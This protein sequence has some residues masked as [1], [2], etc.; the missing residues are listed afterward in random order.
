MSVETENAKEAIRLLRKEIPKHIPQ[1]IGLYILSCRNPELGKV[2]RAS[3]FFMRHMDDLLD[4][5]M[6]LEIDPLSYAYQIRNQIETG[7][8]KGAPQIINLAQFSIETLNKKSRD[9]DNPRNEFLGAIDSIIFDYHRSRER[10]SLPRSELDQYYKKTFFP[11]INLLLIG[12]QSELRA[13]DI[14]TFAY[15]QGRIYTIRDLRTD[16]GRGTINV[17]QE[18]LETAGLS[19]NSSYPDLI[20]NPRLQQWIQEELTQNKQEL[21]KLQWR[22]QSNSHDLTYTICNLYIRSM[23]KF[24]DKSV[25]VPGFEPRSRT[26]N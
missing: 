22:M 23:L 4:G 8:Y 19:T 7:K 26:A 16:W 5:D 24:I 17:P 3:Y 1:V 9:G 12:L 20:Q 13:S 2:A 21:L 18:V 11:V 15:C 6:D 10:K 25:E 14:P